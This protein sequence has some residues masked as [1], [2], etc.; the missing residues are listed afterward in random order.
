MRQSESTDKAAYITLGLM[1]GAAAGVAAGLLTAPRSGKDTRAR[2][3]TQA[4][5]TRDLA[6]EKMNRSLQKSKDM[7]SNI[8]EKTKTRARRASDK[9]KTEADNFAPD[10]V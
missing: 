1:M 8:A 9:A 4:M 2:I 10:E 6:T 7:A 5:D 3:R